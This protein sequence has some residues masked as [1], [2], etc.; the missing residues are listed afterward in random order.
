MADD[1]EKKPEEVQLN[2]RNT[3]LP[4]STIIKKK[5]KLVMMLAL[6]LILAVTGTAGAIFA[7]R[8]KPG[9]PQISADVSLRYLTDEEYTGI[10]TSKIVNPD[11]TDFRKLKISL[12]GD[13]LGKRTVTFPTSLQIRGALNNKTY[14]FA[15]NEI[16]DNPIEKDMIYNCECTLYTRGYTDR[17][18]ADKLNGLLITIKYEENGKMKTKS[19]NLSQAIVLPSTTKK[20]AA[21]KFTGKTSVTTNGRT[22][23]LEELPKNALEETV[24]NDLL[25]TITGEFEKDA[26][27]NG[28]PTFG[29]EMVKRLKEDYKQGCSVQSYIIHHL[30]TLTEKQYNRIDL[31]SIENISSR[32]GLKNCF[33]VKADFTEVYSQKLKRLGTQWPDGRMTRNYYLARVGGSLSP[34]K[35][36]DVS[37]P[38]MDST[39]GASSASVS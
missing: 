37:M 5:R 34:Y 23:K 26:Q 38:D 39:S 8:P 32:Y 7:F 22:Y 17:Q 21:Y 9:P 27:C 31:A 35:I 25:Y 10:G 13:N 30:T 4:R 6:V 33:V 24:A 36:Y 15:G 1:A 18:I 14:W 12:K 29:P 16:Q 20:P 2:E 11:I 28:G 3:R 19:W